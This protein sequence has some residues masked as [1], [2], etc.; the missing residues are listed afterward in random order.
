MSMFEISIRRLVDWASIANA[1]SLF[2]GLPSSSVFDQDVFFSSPCT[3]SEKAVGLRVL[4]SE[5]GYRSL[6][7][8]VMNFECDDGE[9][10]SLCRF[11]SRTF[12]SQVAMGDFLDD[13]VES[14]GL[15]LV[16]EPTGECRRAV[17]ISNGDIFELEVLPDIVTAE[18]A[19]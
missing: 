19:K 9:Q 5:A 12:D 7:D 8:V 11:L 18:N 2:F 15:Y 13:T 14:T 1:F 4:Q 17:E 10:Y 6:I 16:V 3:S